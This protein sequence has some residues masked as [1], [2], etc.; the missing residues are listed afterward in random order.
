VLV[1]LVSPVWNED[2]R[3]VPP[4]VSPAVTAQS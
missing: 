2:L 1:S 4:N 3:L